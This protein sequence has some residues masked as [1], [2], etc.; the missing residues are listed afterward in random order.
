MELTSITPTV[1][2]L[3]ALSHPVRLRMLSLLRA[4]GPATAT[5]LATRLGLNT[6]ST[7]YHLR[8]LAQ[9]GFVVEDA[10]RGNARDRWWRAAHQATTTAPERP[11]D[12]ATKEAMDAYLQSVAVVMTEQLQRAIEERS[13][14]PDAWRAASTYSDWGIRLTP[15]RARA[16]VQA[17]A[18]TVGEIDE[19]DEGE[20]AADFI[21]QI[22]AYPRPG[23]VAEAPA[24]DP[25]SDSASDSGGDPS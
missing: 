11:D 9:H 17:L 16:L 10:E 13:Q 22:N 15:K 24:S 6:G 19:E 2:A 3:K 4:E 14:L 25:T 7:S 1:N 23:T 21:V 5:T 20:D 18:A 8:Q 12:R